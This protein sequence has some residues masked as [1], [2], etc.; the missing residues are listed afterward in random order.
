L[1]HTRI[2]FLD[3]TALDFG[4][5]NALRIMAKHAVAALSYAVVIVN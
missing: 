3:F 1:T 2:T 4:R 5:A